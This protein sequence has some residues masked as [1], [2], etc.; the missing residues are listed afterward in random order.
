MRTMLMASGNAAEEAMA[1]ADLVL[2]PDASGVGLLEFHQIDRMKESG[3]A[4]TLAALPQIVRAGLAMRVT[5]CGVRGSTPA[6]GASF[7]RY[8][9][10][11]SCVAPSPTTVTRRACCSMPA[12]G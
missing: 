9:G 11:T 8:G 5:F 10:Q 2:R 6:P 12:P 3:R 7:V 4:T 1:A